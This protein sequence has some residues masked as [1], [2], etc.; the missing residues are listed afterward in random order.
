MQYGVIY[1]NP[2]DRNWHKTAFVK[3]SAGW[4]ER[5]AFDS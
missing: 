2:N 5:T 4:P 1:A 3:C